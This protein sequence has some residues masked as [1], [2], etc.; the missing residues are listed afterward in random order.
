MTPRGVAVVSVGAVTAVGLSAAQ[1][2]CAVRAGLSGF[3]ESE[4]LDRMYRPI[5]RAALPD[6]ALPPPDP[7]LVEFPGVTDATRRALRLAGTALE[8]V[9][10]GLPSGIPV[11][12]AAERSGSTPDDFLS[13]LALQSGYR[14]GS[15]L[16]GVFDPGR[17]GG[18]RAVEQA[19]RLFETGS[20][21]EAIVGGVETYSVER[22]EA[23]DADRRILS[24]GSSD[25]F[26]PGEAACFLRLVPGRCVPTLTEPP[27]AWVE[28][29]GFGVESGHRYSKEPYRGEGLAKAVTETLSQ[30]RS[31]G[32]VRTVFA[33]LNGESYGAKEWGVAYQ[34][35]ASCFAEEFVMEHPADCVGD[36]GT[37]MSPLMIALAAIGTASG[38]VAAPC[39]VWATS[40]YGDCGSCVVRAASTMES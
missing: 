21:D 23:L 30:A 24:E 7:I 26:V 12:V 11:L 20:C 6:E 35:N 37:A 16:G 40:D 2:A 17:A 27:L 13:L 5:V 32:P 4:I 14:L 25:G 3:G 33:G 1:S 31:V 10:G 39:L 36:T 22:L 15:S 29:L 38:A 28:A 34:R 8:E 19:L 9:A 18:L